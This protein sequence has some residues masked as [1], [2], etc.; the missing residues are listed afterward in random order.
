[1]SGYQPPLSP[2]VYRRRR[3]AVLGGLL[4][5]VVVIVLIIVRPGFGENA[6]PEVDDEEMVEVEATA[7]PP[8]CTPSQIKLTAQTDA[9]R[10]NP[11]EIPQLWLTVENVGFAECEIDV[12]TTKQEYRIT[13]GSDQI[14]SS[15][16]CQKGGV[17]MTIT[18]QPGESRS[19]ES[20][21]WDRTRSSE[22]TCDEARPIMP[23]G[24]ASYH[25]RVFLGDIQSDETRQFILN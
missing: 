9:L 8:P 1:M 4:A 5:L 10:Y 14:W 22:T 18:L 3:L 11:G 16:D 12:S 23:G 25:L 20:I 19:T 2:T 17:P 13:S 6:Q 7:P 24:G 15:K 21:A